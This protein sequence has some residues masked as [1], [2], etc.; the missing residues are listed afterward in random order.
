M[1]QKLFTVTDVFVKFLPQNI[2]DFFFQ[3]D[4]FSLGVNIRLYR[5]ASKKETLMSLRWKDKKLFKTRSAYLPLSS[6]SS[7]STLP[8]TAG[9]SIYN[10]SFNKV[11]FNLTVNKLVKK[12]ASFHKVVFNLTVNRLVKNLQV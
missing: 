7:N 1:P 4:L 3:D 10:Y 11:V 8:A 9:H 5:K 12:F 6:N 2:F